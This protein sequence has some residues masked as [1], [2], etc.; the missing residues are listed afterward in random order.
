M[1][2]YG[3]GAVCGFFLSDNEHERAFGEFRIADLPADLLVPLVYGGANIVFFQQPVS[4]TMGIAR[5]Y[6]R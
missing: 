2:P 5:Q 6:V 4:T 1:L 3:N